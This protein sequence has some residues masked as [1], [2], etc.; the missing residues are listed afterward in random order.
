MIFSSVLPVSLPPSSY[1]HQLNE[2][3]RFRAPL[4]SSHGLAGT[5]ALQLM[6]R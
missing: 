6:L 1:L 4:R 5:N 3:M 2:D